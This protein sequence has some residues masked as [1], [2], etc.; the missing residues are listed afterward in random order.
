[1]F[2]AYCRERVLRCAHLAGMARVYAGGRH[3]E[4]ATGRLTL[5]YRY[6]SGM[7]HATVDYSTRLSKRTGANADCVAE[8]FSSIQHAHE[9]S[10]AIILQQMRAAGTRVQ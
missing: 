2:D 3:S 6:I 1:M 7:E 5:A 9:Q 10:A 4:N 8:R